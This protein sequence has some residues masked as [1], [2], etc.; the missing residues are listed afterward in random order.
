MGNYKW[1]NRTVP[2]LYHENQTKKIPE[3]YTNYDCLLE[4]FTKHFIPG[5]NFIHVSIIFNKRVQLST[6][7]MKEFA[8]QLQKL[9]VLSSPSG[10]R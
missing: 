10:T 3:V 2:D 8:K 5:I 4:K 1:V 9:V 7:F 6:K